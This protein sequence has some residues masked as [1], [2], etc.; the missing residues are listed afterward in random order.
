MIDVTQEFVAEFVKLRHGS[1]LEAANLRTKVGTRLRELCAILSG[2]SDRAIRAKVG[3]A[4]R[5]LAADFPVADQEAIILALGADPARH[6][7]HLSDRVEVLARGLSVSSRTARRRI[8]MALDKLAQEAATELARSAGPPED[9]EQGWYV[10]RFEALLRL[11]TAGPELIERRC[12]VAERDGLKRIVARFSLPRRGND[13]PRVREV[14]AD[15]QQGARIEQWERQGEG[16]FRYLL[17]LPRAL[18]KG[19]EHT[20]IM[21][22]RVPP[23]DPIRPHYAFV[24]LVACES[25]ELRVRFDPDR[26][27]RAVWRLN[28]MAPR[29]LGD[30][31]SPGES[32]V[33]DDA[34]EVFL[35]FGNL[36]QGFGYGMGWLPATDPVAG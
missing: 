31:P 11:D 35:R 21:V 13:T 28:K 32:L 23:D 15:V 10:R 14:F 30:E 2:D 26:L 4:V 1:G 25:F 3:A 12:V 8:E 20:Y 9:P 7:V 27:P 16:H 29:R 36:R 22:F 17:G 33:L 34:G 18:R 19:D 5:R 6:H 24:P